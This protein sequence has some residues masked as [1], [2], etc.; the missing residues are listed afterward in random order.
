MTDPV[1]RPQASQDEMCPQETYG[2]PLAPLGETPLVLQQLRDA[3]LSDDQQAALTTALLRLLALWTRQAT[4]DDVQEG[5]HAGEQRLTQ[6]FDA[7]RDEFR[8]ELA[9]HTEAVREEVRRA[10]AQQDALVQATRAVPARRWD[11]LLWLFTALLG[12]TCAGVLLLVA[13]YVLGW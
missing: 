4:R 7:I 10:V 8:R 6:R 3:G 9:Q 2:E 13:R 12:L 11:G 5:L 1:E